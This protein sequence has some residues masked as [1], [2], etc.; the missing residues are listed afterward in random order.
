[1]SKLKAIDLTGTAC[2]SGVNRL[3]YPVEHPLTQAQFGV[4][5]SKEGKQK[6]VSFLT[7]RRSNSKWKRLGELEHE[8]KS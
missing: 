7:K 1:M 8:P 3:K 4:A 5:S 6:V 2:G